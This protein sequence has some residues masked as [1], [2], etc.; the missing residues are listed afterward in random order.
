MVG[1]GGVVLGGLLAGWMAV[2]CRA[3]G[4]FVQN[5]GPYYHRCLQFPVKG[6]LQNP[7]VAGCQRPRG[8]GPCHFEALR[9]VA[10]WAFWGGLWRWCGVGRLAGCGVRGGGLVECRTLG[11]TTSVLSALF[12]NG[13]HGEWCRAL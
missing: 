7:G 4:C 1:R 11:R 6:H 12:V 10:Q 3:A 9:Q 5:P 8:S 2:A 13:V